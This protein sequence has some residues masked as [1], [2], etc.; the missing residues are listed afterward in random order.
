MAHQLEWKDAFSVGHTV[1]D[2]EH[3]GLLASINEI[4]TGKP[5]ENIEHRVQSLMLLVKNH[6]DHEDATLRE[7]IERGPEIPAGARAVS[8]EAIWEHIRG[9]EIA[10]ARLTAIG[11][12]IVNTGVDDLPRHCE[13]LKRWFIN[14]AV[15]HDAHLKS[16]FQAL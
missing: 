15:K 4:C 7:I 16:V 6:F 5:V 2:M 12:A 10:L 13:N 1:L 8:R 11:Q 9:H 14:H 3:R